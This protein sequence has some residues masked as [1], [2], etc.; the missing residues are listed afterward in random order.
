MSGPLIAVPEFGGEPEGSIQ[1]TDFLKKFRRFMMYLHITEDERM[2]ES[3]GDHLKSSSPAE[4][5]F[6]EQD[7]S[8]KAFKVVEAAFLERFPPVAKAKKTETELERDLCE[9][10]LKVEELGKME[11]YQG[12]DVWSHVVFAEKALSLAKQA[13]ISTG[14]NSIW[15]VRDELPEIIR[16]KVKETYANWT[17]FCSAIKEVEMSHIRDGV[18]KYQKEKEEKEKVDA[19]IAGL[20]RAQQQQ[21]RPPQPTVP[22]SPMSNASNALQSMTIRN[23]RSTPA[24]TTNTT[25][26]AAA[27][28][29]NPFTSSTG[30]R[31]NLFPPVTNTDRDTLRNSLTFY[32]LQPNTQEGNRVWIEQAREWM[33]KHG[34]GPVTIATG[35]PLRPGGAPPGSGECYGCGYTGHHRNSGQCT[36]ELINHRERTFRTICGR[37]LR[38]A[39]AAQVNLVDDAVDNF[40]SWLGD[41]ALTSTMNQGNGEGPPA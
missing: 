31:G 22:L 27:T 24:A 35:F 17:E 34:N 5:W 36:T 13:K 30:G 25:Q 14:T 41:S 32:P 8:K 16:Q 38:S 23:T 29:A 18:K 26:P 9:L 3:F 11:K 10:R 28:N 19:A 7:A 4:E 40:Q 1:S 33:A 6:K 15:K 20:H 2:V 12:E 39:S 21:R 37:I